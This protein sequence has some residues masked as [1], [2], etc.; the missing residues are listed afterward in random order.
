VARGPAKLDPELEAGIATSL[1]LFGPLG[2]LTVR[3]MFGGAGI[4]CDGLIFAVVLDG[5]IYLK[6][7]EAN[8]GAFIQASCP[9]VTMIT[10][11]NKVMQMSYRRLPDEALDDMDAA[12]RWGRLGLGAAQRAK[13]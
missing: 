4:Y 11:D 6:A 10:K 9:P 5:D 12:L 13:K 1:E 7:D 2:H 3:K 8:L